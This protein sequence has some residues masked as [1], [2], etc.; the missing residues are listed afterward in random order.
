MITWS[1]WIAITAGLM[2]GL[3]LVAQ[4]AAHHAAAALP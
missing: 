1:D 2:L 3:I 4:L